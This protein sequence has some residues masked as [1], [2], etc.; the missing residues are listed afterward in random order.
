MIFQFRLKRDNW[1][2]DEAAE[3]VRRGILIPAMIEDVI[4]PLGFRQSQTADLTGWKGDSAHP[5]LRDLLDAVSAQLGLERRGTKRRPPGAVVTPSPPLPVD[6]KEQVW[7]YLDVKDY[8]KALSLLQK[9]ADAG[10]TYGMFNLGWLYEN[11]Q[12]VAQNYG[13]ARQWYQKAAE[14]G[15]TDAVQALSRLHS[16]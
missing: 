12:G 2:K 7:R 6:W 16:K 1:V 4:A 5:Q 14:A 8:A 3:G 9:G 11:G 10:D 15:D 13:K